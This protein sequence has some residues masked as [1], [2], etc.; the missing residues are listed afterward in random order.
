MKSFLTHI[1]EVTG[2]SSVDLSSKSKMAWEHQERRLAQG[3][4]VIRHGTRE[5]APICIVWISCLYQGREHPG[6]LISF[7]SEVRHKGRRRKAVSSQTTKIESDSLHKDLDLDEWMNGSAISGDKEIWWRS[8]VGRSWGV[9]CSAVSLLCLRCLFI[10]YPF[11]SLC[12]HFLTLF[13]SI[14]YK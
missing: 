7:C 14:C 13:P 2:E 8:H 4:I 5:R 1:I 6:F 9:K 3:F 10:I 12:S 11:L